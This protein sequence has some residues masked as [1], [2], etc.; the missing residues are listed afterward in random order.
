MSAKKIYMK[1]VLTAALALS[2]IAGTGITSLS[3]S[4]ATP[5]PTSS[6]SE[7]VS[8]FRTWLSGVISTRFDTEEAKEMM[9]KL[10][11]KVLSMIP[12]ETKAK[13]EETIQ[14]LSD[15]DFPEEMIRQLI[16]DLPIPFSKMS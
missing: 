4:A 2:I 13:F 9:A 11:E 7:K 6:I 5:A 12:E 16:S 14:L 3:A 10:S 8:Q 1:R 15:E